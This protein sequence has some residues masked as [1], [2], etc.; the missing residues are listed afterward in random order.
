[1][2]VIRNYIQDEGVKSQHFPSLYSSKDK[3]TPRKIV[4]IGIKLFGG[5]KGDQK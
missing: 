4:M 2:N 5:M 1:M 3:V